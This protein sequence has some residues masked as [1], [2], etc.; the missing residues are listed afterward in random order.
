MTGIKEN[1][2]RSEDGKIKRKVDFK[3]LHIHN[4]YYLARRLPYSF[5]SIFYSFTLNIML[6]CFWQIQFFGKGNKM[7]LRVFFYHH[8]PASHTSALLAI[9]LIAT[10]YYGTKTRITTKTTTKTII[11]DNPPFINP[12]TTPYNHVHVL[13]F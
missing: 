5:T 11:K 4:T 7:C 13:Q 9:F 12:Y 10:I 3:C 8:H 1:A 6:E 2:N